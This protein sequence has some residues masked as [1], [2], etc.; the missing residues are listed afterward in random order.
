MHSLIVSHNSFAVVAAC[1]T[2]VLLCSVIH[3]APQISQTS[4]GAGVFVQVSA[5]L[6]ALLHTSQLF[7]S[8]PAGGIILL[9]SSLIPNNTTIILLECRD[10]YKS[11]NQCQ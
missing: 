4:S 7:C 2:I 11:V 8:V 6:C 10:E 3:E 9:S 1:R 5:L